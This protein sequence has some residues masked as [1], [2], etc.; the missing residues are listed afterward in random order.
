MF[1]IN[2]KSDNID[3]FSYD[4]IEAYSIEDDHLF[5][6]LNSGEERKYK[7]INVEFVN[8]EGKS[9]SGLKNMVNVINYQISHYNTT[10][11]I[12]D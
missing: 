7:F 6:R 12:T 1:K 3:I 10:N 5:I 4:N 8:T 9:T 11:G 2:L